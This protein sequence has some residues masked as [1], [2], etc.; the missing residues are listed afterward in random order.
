M[1]PHIEEKMTWRDFRNKE[2]WYVY[3]MHH[4][5]SF[6]IV[7][8][9]HVKELRKYYK[10]QE[11]PERGFE[12][13]YAY[14]NPLVIIHP[15][16]YIAGR[17][18]QKFI[19]LKARYRKILGV[20]V[21]DS[22]RVSDLAVHICNLVDGLIVPSTWSKKAY[23]DSGVIP[24]VYVVP[25][26]LSKHF[27]R[28]PRTPPRKELQ[29]LHLLKKKKKY[30]FLLFFLWHSAGRKGADLVY[31][32]VN[33]LCESRNNVVLVL[34]SSSLSFAQSL[35]FDK[36]K[37]FLISGWLNDDEIVD[38]YDLCDIYLLFSR[39]GGFEINGL[40][41]LAR[42]EIVLA[43]EKGSWTDYLPKEYLLPI[44][45]W[46]KVFNLNPYHIGYGCE[47]DVD[48][49]V[50]K[51]IKI[52]DNIDKWKEKARKYAVEVRKKYSWENVGKILKNVIDKYI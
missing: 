44:K 13:I 16:L 4:V 8:E 2:L 9:H 29:L 25:H 48:K 33:K 40:E 43:G 47:I 27:Y 50:D 12:N 51:L 36:N 19:W 23:K 14:S 3:P 45:K 34:K 39:G 11:V 7:A 20:E 24:P 31:H 26:G 35:A 21:A 22:D 1:T 37:T 41:A 38:L 5:V 52:I 17:N 10:V 6:R 46:V 28:K 32:T 49:A 18:L 42:G 30:V 15:L